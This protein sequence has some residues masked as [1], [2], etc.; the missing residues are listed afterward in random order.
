MSGLG[1]NAFLKERIFD[2]LGMTSTV[3]REN[4]W[5]LIPNRG[6]SYWDNGTE[7][8]HCV[9][10]YGNYGTTSLHTTARDLMRWMDNY[11]NPTICKKETMERMLWVG[12]GMPPDMRIKGPLDPSMLV[13]QAGKYSR[14]GR[15]AF[16]THR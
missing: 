4:Y 7:Y 8:F 10:N 9:L 16:R 11:R 12:M 1:F 2:P 13:F 5:Q 15:I 3:V 6:V 14:C